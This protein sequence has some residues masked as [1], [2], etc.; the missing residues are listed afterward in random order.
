MTV[1]SAPVC[2]QWTAS[3]PLWCESYY[4]RSSQVW[5]VTACVDNTRTLSRSRKSGCYCKKIC[6]N[7]K[8]NENQLLNNKW[9]WLCH[10]CY[11]HSFRILSSMNLHICDWCI[12]IFILEKRFCF[13][14]KSAL[15]FLHT[16]IEIPAFC[17]SQE[18]AYRT[19]VLLISSVKT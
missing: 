10:W 16:K 2:Y 8:H 1:V 18:T 5:H 6:V 11:E 14:F 9:R 12:F 15:V 3:K 19:T 13:K 4:H 17:R 7:M